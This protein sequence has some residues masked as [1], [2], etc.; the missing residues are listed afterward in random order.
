M[1]GPMFSIIIPVYNTE[2]ELE[3]C[4]RSVTGQTFR[5]LELILVDDGSRDNSGALCDAFAAE[6]PRVKVI[7][8][9]NSGCS[10][11]RNSGVRAAQGEYLLFLDSDDMWDEADA[12]EQIVCIVKEKP[13]DV[14]CFGVKIYEDDG[15]FVKTRVPEEAAEDDDSK[16]AVLRRLIYTNQYFSASYVKALRREYF[17]ENGLFFV[18]GLLSGEDGEWSARIMVTCRSIAVFQ[19]AFYKRI[20]RK[21]GGITSAIGK[22]NILDVFRAIERGLEFIDRKAESDS[23]KQLY[24]E[25]W[26]YQYAMLYGL[27]YRLHS[28]PEYPALIE[29]FRKYKWLLRYDHV[30]KV[31]AVRRLV[32][33]IGVRGAVPALSLYYRVK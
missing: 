5:D 18:K 20:R 15:T 27:A 1:S 30:D 28:D 16:E 21:E 6:D 8:Q 2:K 4:V 23:L 19:S 22:K 31:R 33:L 11:A 25:Y 29:R 24:L 26:A 17:I 3:R 13:V 32:R 7:H 10:E 12:L 14:V 9:Q